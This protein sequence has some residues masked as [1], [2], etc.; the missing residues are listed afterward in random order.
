[1]MMANHKPAK[2]LTQLEEEPVSGFFGATYTEIVSVM[3]KVLLFTVL[4]ALLLSIL[5]RWEVAT[6]IA[7][8]LSVVV[9][10]GLIQRIADNRAD[11][12]LYYHRHLTTQ[13]TTV[14]IQPATIYQRERN[15][16]DTK[17]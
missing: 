17:K 14:F 11:K 12:P 10:Y 4:C 8:L 3:R 15:S 7:I 2:T 5:I 9:F 16:H 13:K 6:I 1:M